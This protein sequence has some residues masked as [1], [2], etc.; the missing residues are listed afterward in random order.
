MSL[1]RISLYPKKTS[2]CLDV[3]I[4]A[5]RLFGKVQLKFHEVAVI[6]PLIVQRNLDSYRCKSREKRKEKREKRN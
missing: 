4:A 1:R 6:V 5:R 2:I 3:D